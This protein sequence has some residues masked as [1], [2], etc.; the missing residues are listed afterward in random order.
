MAIFLLSLLEKCNLNCKH[1]RSEKKGRMLSVA[2]IKK[3]IGKVKASHASV[4]LTGGEPLMHPQIEDIIR[5]FK[6]SGIKVSLSTNGT[7]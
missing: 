1:C 3:I 6:K 5:L 7:F 4:N 2:D